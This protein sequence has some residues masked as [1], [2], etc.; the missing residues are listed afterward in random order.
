MLIVTGYVQ[1]EPS[2]LSQ[3][4]NEFRVLATATRQRT[5]NLSYD[6]AV[7]DPQAGRFLVIERW[8]DQASLGAHLE[9]ADTVAFVNRWRV[10]MW[11]DIQK[12]DASKG[13]CLMD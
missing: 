13:R 8:E 7:D 4:Y 3:F 6:G 9:A 11:G 1:V 5:G 10:R 12:Y 2:E